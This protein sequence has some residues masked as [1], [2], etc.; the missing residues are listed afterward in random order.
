M[1]KGARLPLLSSSL[2]YTL[3]KYPIFISSAI[4]KRIRIAS[5][6]LPLLAASELGHLLEDKMEAM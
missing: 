3:L 6:S 4:R 5:T 2:P 1:L